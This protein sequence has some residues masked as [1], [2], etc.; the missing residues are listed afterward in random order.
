MDA[1]KYFLHGSISQCSDFSAL[2]YYSITRIGL[3]YGI[4]CV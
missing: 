3:R 2:N 4:E 1:L